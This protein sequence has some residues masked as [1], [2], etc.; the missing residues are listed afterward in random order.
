MAADPIAAAEG[1]L[2]AWFVKAPASGPETARELDPHGALVFDMTALRRE[3][4][5]SERRAAE[6]RERA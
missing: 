1:A 5:E 6:R 2:A 4:R 3:A